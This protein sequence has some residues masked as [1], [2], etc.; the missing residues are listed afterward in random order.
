MIPTLATAEIS[1]HGK[2]RAS[3]DDPAGPALT[4]V[5]EW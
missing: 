5:Q 2:P 1:S 4:R 3:G